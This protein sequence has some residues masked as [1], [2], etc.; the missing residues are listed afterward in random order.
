M[1]EMQGGVFRRYLSYVWRSNMARIV[2]IILMAALM[3]MPS[4]AFE[5]NIG[6]YTIR[7]DKPEIET[8]GEMPLQPIIEDDG[9]FENYMKI[10]NSNKEAQLLL[11]ELDYEK[12]GFI[13]EDTNKAYTFFI[14]MEGKVYKMQRGLIGPDVVVEGSLKGLEN[15]YNEGNYYKMQKLLKMPFKMRLKLM[16]MRVW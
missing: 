1:Q 14:D 5:W 7:Y 13:D 8:I 2:I 11:K 9:K 16:W 4:Y 10:A 3:A 15:A 12:I 6:K